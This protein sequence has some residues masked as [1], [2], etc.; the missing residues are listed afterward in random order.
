MLHE[1]PLSSAMF[2]RAL[3][4]IGESA[5]VWAFD[6][7]GCGLSDPPPQAVEIPDYAGA[8]VQAIQ[9]LGLREY[10]LVGFHT[11]ASLAVQIALL[12]HSVSGAILSGVPVFSDAERREYLE[13]WAPPVKPSPDG[14]HLRWAWDRFT[15]I[16]E[17]P[18]DLV[19]YGASE[20]LGNLDRY[21]W[22][23]NAAFRY[24]PAP[25]LVRISCPILLLSPEHDKMKPCDD[26]AFEVA[27]NASRTIIAD[28]RMP[29]PLRQPEVFSRIVLDF[30]SRCGEAS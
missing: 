28:A 30:I 19:H 22:A 2:T 7:P 8:L 17:G 4:L 24:D 26:R 16:W 15:A 27:K 3:P 5:R 14:R 13:S 25:D 12:E 29:F 11:G 23:Y 21:H 10:S 6:T 9:S 18:A 1:S 20:M